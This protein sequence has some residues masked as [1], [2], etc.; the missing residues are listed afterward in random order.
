MNSQAM[1][2]DYLTTV[3][4]AIITLARCADAAFGS[5]DQDVPRRMICGA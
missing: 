1:F 2:G 3:K 4:S 5:L